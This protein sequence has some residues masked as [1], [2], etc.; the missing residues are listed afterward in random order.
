MTQQIRIP[1]FQKYDIAATTDPVFGR[2]GPDTVGLN[3]LLTSGSSTTVT[4]VTAGTTPFRGLNVGA[5]LSVNRDG[6]WDVVYLTAIDAGLDQ[7]TVDTAVNW[8][9]GVQG[10]SGR[11]FHYRNF[12]SGQAVTDGWINRRQFEDMV[13]QYA[14]DDPHGTVSFY[15]EGRIRGPQTTPIT[16]VNTF[17]SATATEGFIRIPEGVDEIRF[18][19]LVAS[20]TGANLVNAYAL[21]MPRF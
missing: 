12:F 19:L 14:L 8:E 5:E 16:L 1:L 13:I 15:T 21:G 6:T 18:G 7:G 11:Q 17:S 3:R 20:D 2:F 9:T 4:A 10:T